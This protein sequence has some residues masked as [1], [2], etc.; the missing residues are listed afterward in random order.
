MEILE[1]LHGLGWS[2]I[3]RCRMKDVVGRLECVEISWDLD[4]IPPGSARHTRAECPKRLAWG[5]RGSRARKEGTEAKSRS[6]VHAIDGIVRRTILIL[7]LMAV[8]PTAPNA[9]AF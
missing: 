6:V 8:K 1:L 7:P 9:A 2:G 5:P 3:G 4:E